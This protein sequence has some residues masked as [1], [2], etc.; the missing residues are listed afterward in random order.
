[1]SDMKLPNINDNGTVHPIIDNSFAEP[2]DNL[3]NTNTKGERPTT[4]AN[5][6]GKAMHIKSDPPPLDGPDFYHR[7]NNHVLNESN[8]KQPGSDSDDYGR[9]GGESRPLLNLMGP[10]LPEAMKEEKFFYLL[11][12]INLVYMY[13]TVVLPL[14]VQENTVTPMRPG[15]STNWVL[16]M[17]YASYS[18]IALFN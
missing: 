8:L 17:L 2:E 16:H 15:Q 3:L 10:K 7:G 11:Q 4:N 13:C 18:A 14:V 9:T 5:L 1:M 12:V 6:T